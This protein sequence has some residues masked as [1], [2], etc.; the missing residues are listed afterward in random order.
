MRPRVRVTPRDANSRRAASCARAR[1]IARGYKGEPRRRVE[2]RE[3]R[4]QDDD[5]LR[6]CDGGGTP[7]GGEDQRPGHDEPAQEGDQQG[8]RPVGTR[9]GPPRA[10][11][12]RPTCCAR[13]P[14]WPPRC[15]R[16]RSGSASSKGLPVPGGAA[17]AGRAA[18][19]REP[20]AVRE[21]ARP[22]RRRSSRPSDGPGRMMKPPPRRAAAAAVHPRATNRM[23]RMTGDEQDHLCRDR[24]RRC[25]P[26]ALRCHSSASPARIEQHRVDAGADAAGKS[27]V[28]KRGVIAVVMMTLRERVGERAF[29]PVADLDA[30]LALGRGDEEQRAVVGLGLA[31]LPVAEQAVAVIL[32]GQVPAGSAR[33]R[34][35]PDR[36]SSPRRP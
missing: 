4:G 14:G 13:P 16:G 6:Q 28:L 12:S 21:A 19:A 31:D 25:G 10:R 24:P 26:S 3:Q 33:W 23:T 1:R 2:C 35:R 9:P 36:R 22:T 5:R 32:D 15:G 18:P 8:D 20:A 7:L 27:P 30:D 17:A 29:E 34:P 11:R